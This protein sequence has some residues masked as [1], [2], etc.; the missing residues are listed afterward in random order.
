MNIKILEV[1]LQPMKDSKFGITEHDNGYW[2]PFRTVDISP[3]I[4]KY[5]FYKF[6]AELIV[7]YKYLESSYHENI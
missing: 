4:I 5:R 2:V 1:K 6:N 7:K 3:T